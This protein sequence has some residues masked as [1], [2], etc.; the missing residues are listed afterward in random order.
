MRV[1]VYCASSRQCDPIYHQA[2]ARL[3]RELARAGHTTV[4]GGGSVG[5]M[6][7]LA[8]AALAAGG[9]VIG[10][11]FDVR[12][13][14]FGEIAPAKPVE[15]SK[16]PLKVRKAT[17]KAEVARMQILA[18]QR[19]RPKLPE[20]FEAGFQTRPFVTFGTGHRLNTHG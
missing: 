9:R 12:R 3:G 2:A 6:G 20:L 16:S 17:A 1:C 7:H 14:H 13:R 8:D 10:H 4:Y 5:S 11:D 19:R 18:Y 15:Q